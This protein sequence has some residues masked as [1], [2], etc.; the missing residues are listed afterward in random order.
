M[1]IIK[2]NVFKLQ[3]DYVVKQFIPIYKKSFS[4]PLGCMQV[5]NIN[6]TLI[7]SEEKK[8]V[9]QMQ[10]GKPNIALILALGKVHTVIFRHIRIFQGC[11]WCLGVKPM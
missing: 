5:L 2:I 3:N 11:A 6:G 10:V 9:F 8:P 1:E 4:E 7:G